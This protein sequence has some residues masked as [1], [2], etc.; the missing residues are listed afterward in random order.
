MLD[1][2]AD[3]AEIL[4][5]MLGIGFL[6]GS[7]IYSGTVPCMIGW[8]ANLI[9]V[10]Y[11]LVLSFLFC[12]IIA[13]IIGTSS[14]T[15]GTIGVI[16][17]GVATIQGVSP[18][19][20]AAAVICGSFLGQITSVVSD[21]VNWNSSI[22]GNTTQSTVMLCLPAEA[23]G[24]IVSLVFFFIVGLRLDSAATPDY[25]FITCNNIILYGNKK[26]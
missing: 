14:A 9:S 8:L 17:L 22:T 11:V 10:K 21:M 19:I 16:M 23:I 25:S 5:I 6:I 12:A 7:W 24:V 26:M 3:N 2:V 13:A 20:A 1:S 18:G 15:M 4:V